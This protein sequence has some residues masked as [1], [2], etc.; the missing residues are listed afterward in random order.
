MRTGSGPLPGRPSDRH[1]LSPANGEKNGI[2]KELD[3]AAEEQRT[4][5]FPSSTSPGPRRLPRHRLAEFV[6][7]EVVK[8]NGHD[9]PGNHVLEGHF[10][11]SSPATWQPATRSRSRHELRVKVITLTE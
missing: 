10:V 11:D 2:K 7:D 6:I 8:W 1:L 4:L 5:L 9:D 3:E